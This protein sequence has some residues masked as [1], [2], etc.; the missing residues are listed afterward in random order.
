MTDEKSKIH[1]TAE[2]VREIVKEVPIYKDAIQPA[3]KEIG[4]ALQTVAKSIN[5]ALAPVSA[6]VWGYDQIKDFVNESLAERFKDLPKERLVTP[7]P[8]IA[9]PTLEALRYAGHEPL[10]RELYANLLAT[11][12]DAKT[13]EEAH[14]AFVEILRQLTPD[15]ARI[16]RLFG[17]SYSHPIITVRQN[18]K[19]PS[20]GGIDILRHF[21]LL[22][23][24]AGCSHPH[25]TSSYLD[26]LCRL[27]LAEIP[28]YTH[29]TAPGVYEPLEKHQTVLDTISMI[30]KQLDKTSKII[31][32]NLRVTTLGKQFCHACVVKYNRS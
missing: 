9:G 12:M 14:P 13:A 25:L 17:K 15:E 5:V 28:A 31:R 26:N 7:S 23:Y 6:L 4:T 32:E 1:E 11:S 22:G 29:L 18:D 30:E 21:S 3:A 19:D 2:V 10:L 16:I 20:K 8:T 24:E 27:G